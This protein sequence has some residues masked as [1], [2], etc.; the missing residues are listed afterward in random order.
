MCEYCQRYYCPSSCP[1]APA[2]K[3]ILIGLIGI[4]FQCGKRVF[5]GEEFQIKDE[6]FFCGSCAI[7]AKLTTRIL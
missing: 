2:P 5:R 6:D 7:T 4:C 3:R 1:G